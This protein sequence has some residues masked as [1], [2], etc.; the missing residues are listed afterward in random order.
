VWRLYGWFSGLMAFGSCVGIVSWV[1]KMQQLASNVQASDTAQKNTTSGQLYFASAANWQAGFAVNYAV[2]FLCLT[3]A[4]LMVLDRMSDFAMPNGQVTD[5]DKKRWTLWERIVLAAVVTVSIV[6]VS[7]NV[8]AVPYWFLAASYSLSAHSSFS[9][10]N[11]EESRVLARTAKEYYDQGFNVATVQMACEVAVLLLIICTFAVVGLYCLR[12]VRS[13]MS[14]AA[15]HSPASSAEG[16]HLRK[17]ILFTTGVVF[18]TFLIRSVQSV[19][20]A[21]AFALSDIDAKC[22]ENSEKTFSGMGLCNP[23]CYNTWTH[24]LRWMQRTPQFQVIIVVIS[25]P[26][27]LVVSLWGMTSPSALKL[28]REAGAPSLAVR[29]IP[30]NA[31]AGADA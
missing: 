26:L 8:A 19:M 6:G 22:P 18:V 27:A 9:K 5:D 25:S 30:R 7:G 13:I 28:M 11:L 29:L 12:R 15:S 16:N 4:Q 14:S 24:M 2:E 21:L 23:E 1:S 3:A 10:N 17:Q 20:Q 31:Q